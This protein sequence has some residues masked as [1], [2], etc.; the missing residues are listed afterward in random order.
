MPYAEQQ[1][2]QTGDPEHQR[3]VAFQANYDKIMQHQIEVEMP[4]LIGAITGYCAEQG[5]PNIYDPEALA[6]I[7]SKTEELLGIM[8]E[9]FFKYHEDETQIQNFETE[10]ANAIS[11]DGSVVKLRL[12]ALLD[13]DIKNIAVKH[14]LMDRLD[15]KMPWEEVAKKKFWLIGK[16]SPWTDKHEEDMLSIPSP[17]KRLTFIETAYIVLCG[18]DIVKLISGPNNSG[19]T[20]TDLPQAAYANWL[21]RNYWKVSSHPKNDIPLKP[22]SLRGNVICY[23][24]A[25]AIT[26]KIADQSQ[27]NCISVTEGMKAAIN[28]RSFDIEAL[29]MILELFTERASHNYMVFEYQLAKRPPKLLLSRFNVWQ[30]KMNQKWMVVSMPSSIYRTEDSMYLKEIEKIK[31]DEAITAWFTHR[32]KNVNFVAYMKSPKLKLAT[33]EKFKDYRHEEKLRYEKGKKVRK[34]ITS[35]Y[36][37]QVEEVWTKVKQG[38]MAYLNVPDWLQKEKRYGIEQVKQF[39]RDYDKFDRTR[40]FA[41]GSKK[42]EGGDE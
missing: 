4:K 25:A 8:K 26:E 5:S 22:Y 35:T 17:W 36:F 38:E 27:Y 9:L 13:L 34:S 1:L 33:Y 11:I 3:Q 21:L 29:D 14:K 40:K 19:K 10:I 7:L 42:E 20:W 16:D 24:E 18:G 41:A 31:G 6:S 2:P 30:Q 15:K 23:P 12:K 28:L 37:A 39:M 32:S